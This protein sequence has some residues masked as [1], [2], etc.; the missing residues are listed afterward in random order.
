VVVLFM[1][2]GIVGSLQQL[3]RKRI[4]P[5]NDAKPQPALGGAAQ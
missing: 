2:E 3:F 5:P 1:P 4:R